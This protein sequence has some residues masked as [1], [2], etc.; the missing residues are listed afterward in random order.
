MSHQL[1]CMVYPIV[2]IGFHASSWCENGLLQ[3]STCPFFSLFPRFRGEIQRNEWFQ[4]FQLAPHELLQPSIWCFPFCFLVSQVRSNWGPPNWS[5]LTR[6][7]SAQKKIS[8]A[9]QV[10]DRGG[11]IRAGGKRAW[12]PAKERGSVQILIYIYIHMDMI[13]I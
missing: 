9:Q 7:P 10:K 1:G 8:E 11:H 13:S 12:S 2:F 6:H 4:P 3:P 5:K